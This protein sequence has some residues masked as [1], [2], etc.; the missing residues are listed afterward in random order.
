MTAH[1][2]RRGRP[3]KHAGGEAA[4]QTQVEQLAA[5]YGWRTYHT[6]DSRRSTPGFP[7]LVMVRGPE[8]VFAELK[9][10]TGR[11]TPEQDAW[12]ADLETVS[13]AVALELDERD[14]ARRH[15]GYGTQPAVDPCVDVYVWRPSDWDTLQ[16][17]LARGRNLVPALNPPAGA[18]PTFGE[19]MAQLADENGEVPS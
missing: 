9:T 8:L 1:D 2:R 10:N 3:A 17:R 11:T 14:N 15:T 7:D 16:R 6:H 4:F 19:R 18:R 12:I 5:F 13:R